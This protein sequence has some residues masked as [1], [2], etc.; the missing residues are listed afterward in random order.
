MEQQKRNFRYI[1]INGNVIQD[2]FDDE[3]M[4]QLFIAFAEKVLGMKF[5]SGTQFGIDLVSVD[6]PTFG[7]EGENASWNGDR[8]V[9]SQ[10]DIFNLGFGT[11]NM[12]NWKW[13]YVGL[14]EYSEK[15]YGKYLKIHAGFEKNIYFRVNKQLD[16]IC[17]VDASV[18]RDSSKVKFVFNRKVSNSKNPEDWICIPKKFVRTFNKQPNGEWLENGPYCGP[19]QKEL[20]DMEKEY[21]QQ[22]VREVM[23]VN[24]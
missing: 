14:G 7:A 17:L 21:T 23:F 1:R 4:R 24:K 10:Q 6:D 15:N 13:H 2:P 5:I 8:W 16:Q 12:Q 18:L 11:L 9:S 19:T 3:D 20:A 22:R